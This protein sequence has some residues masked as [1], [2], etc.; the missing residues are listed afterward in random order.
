MSK[1][2]SVKRTL[3][4]GTLL[5]TAA[6][7]LSRFIGFFYKIFLSRT[8]GAEG[9]GIYQLIFPVMALC[10]SLTSAGIQTSVSRFVSSEIGKQNP[11]GAKSHFFANFS[12]KDRCIRF[13]FLLYIYFIPDIFIMSNAYIEFHSM[14]EKHLFLLSFY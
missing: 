10:F 12:Y 5:L 1:N 14:P 4:T 9:L 13:E 6:G 2:L 11:A 3:F 7:I 8:I